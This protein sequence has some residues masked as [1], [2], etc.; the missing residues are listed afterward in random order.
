MEV[1]S[2]LFADCRTLSRRD[3][4][5]QPGVLTPGVR[6]KEGR[7]A[8]KISRRES[9][10]S[11][12]VTPHH[13]FPRLPGPAPLLPRLVCQFLLGDRG[14]ARFIQ[15]CRASETIQGDTD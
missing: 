11:R 5:T 13:E 2:G 3:Y 4:R 7:N 15:G 6:N 14:F 8:L 1:R 10:I 9:L 12:L